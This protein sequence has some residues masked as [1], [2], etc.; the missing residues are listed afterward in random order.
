[1]HWRR[2][3]QPTPVF[4]PGESQGR[5]ES[6]GLMSMGS[7]RVGHDWSDLA[8]EE[9]EKKKGYEKIFEAIIVENFP[10]MEKKIVN[11]V[12]EAQR[13]PYR[14][15]PRRNMPRHMLIKLRKT[16]HKKK[17]KSSKGEATSNIQGKPH[18]L[19]SWFFSRNSAGQKE[20]GRIY[21]K[22]WKGE[23]LQPKLLYR[24][25]SHSKLMEKSKAFQT[26]K[27]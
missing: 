18:M 3:W 9:E 21:L 20:Y 4:L 17:I 14:M 2:K 22:C 8:A 12:Q 10:N 19:N 7:H 23:N 25:G 11:Q 27:S 24:Q 1:M 5:G 26:G 6:G 16:K 15:N 13:V